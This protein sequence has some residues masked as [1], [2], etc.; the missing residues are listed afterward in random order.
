M[1]KYTNSWI[2]S[3]L[4]YISGF[5]NYLGGLISPYLPEAH[6]AAY[7]AFALYTLIILGGGLLAIMARNLIRAMLGLVLTFLGVAGMY[8]LLASPFLAFMQLLIYVGAVCVLIFFAIML[9]RNYSE[10]EES[11]LPSV[12]AFV[13]GLLSLLAPLGIIAPFIIMHG[14]AIPTKVPEKTG[15]D[16]L[17]AGLLKEYVLPFELISIILLVAMAGAVYLAFRGFKPIKGDNHP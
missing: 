17:G 6:W 9:T 14:A 1:E 3:V 8:L 13:Y 16:I 5:I 2:D 7:A 4:N 11:K 15:T 10:G 12:S